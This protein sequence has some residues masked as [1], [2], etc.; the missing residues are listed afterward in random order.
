MSHSLV[1]GNNTFCSEVSFGVFFT[2]GQQ[3]MV[4]V[5]VELKLGQAVSLITQP[6][7]GTIFENSKFQKIYYVHSENF[8]YLSFQVKLV[9]HYVSLI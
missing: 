7:L 6:F 1:I 9:C 5:S 2:L 3:S 4:S 8:N